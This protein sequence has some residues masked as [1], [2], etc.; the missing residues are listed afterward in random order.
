MNF[1]SLETIQYI[2]MM[3]RDSVSMVKCGESHV[4]LLRSGKKRQLRCYNLIH[5]FFFFFL[6]L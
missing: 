3:K 5:Q 1:L 4:C 2:Y 6:V